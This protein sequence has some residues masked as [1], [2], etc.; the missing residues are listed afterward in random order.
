MTLDDYRKILS[1][2][3]DPF[4]EAGIRSRYLILRATSAP[5]PAITDLVGGGEPI[6]IR[7]SRGEAAFRIYQF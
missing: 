7:N 2:G 5:T 1:S 3:N 6:S 4:A